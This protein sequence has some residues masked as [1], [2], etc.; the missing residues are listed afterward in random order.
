MPRAAKNPRSAVILTALDL[1]TKAVLRH[2]EET[3]ERVIDGTVFYQGRFEDWD[4]AV[5]ECG[6]GNTSA[7]AIAE[8]AIANFR[9][10]VAL[11][12]GI[13]GGIK[14]VSIGDVVVADKMYGYESGKDD[15]AGF[16]P[17][18][19]VKN[20]AHEIEQ[21][22]RALPKS[23]AWCRR[24]NVDLKHGS[25][26]V[27]VGPIAGGE[28]VVASTRS[29]TAEFL[30]KYYSDAIAVEMEGKGFLE[31]VNIN[32][33]V[34]GGVVRGISDLLSGKSEADEGGSPSAIF[35]VSVASGRPGLNSRGSRPRLT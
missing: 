28:R 19:E 10:S 26:K 5:A 24:L 25:P 9:P 3:G 21:R 11:F 33:L 7:A 31:A 13:A 1:E 34:H 29:A 4:I 27:F 30:R 16:R 23:D 8:R 18:A 22:G 35:G 6:A 15:E 17:R 32:T 2:L 20:S 14:D 12:V